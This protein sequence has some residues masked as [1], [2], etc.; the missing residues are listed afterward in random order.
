M[1]HFQAVIA[2]ALQLFSR[3][4]T[5][6]QLK[7]SPS[8]ARLLARPRCG[9]CMIPADV[10]TVDTFMVKIIPP[11]LEIGQRVQVLVCEEGRNGRRKDWKLGVCISTAGEG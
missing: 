6:V 1:T 5:G 2:H 4:Y 8:L 11:L 3:A 10:S 7:D 9:D